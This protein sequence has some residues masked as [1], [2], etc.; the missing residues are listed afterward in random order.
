MQ[1]HIVKTNIT[2]PTQL[3]QLKTIMDQQNQVATWSIDM[4]DVD[5]VLVVN[6]DFIQQDELIRIVNTQHIF[7]TELP[8]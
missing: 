3:L 7:C 5:R 4:H 8:E 2:T 6:T 1:R